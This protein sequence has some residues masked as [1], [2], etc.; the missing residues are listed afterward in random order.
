[1]NKP[2]PGKDA[3]GCL[4]EGYS[5]YMDYGVLAVKCQKMGDG[6]SSRAPD[7]TRAILGTY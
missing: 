7:L 3:P 4:I 6:F 5:S 1:M 2:T